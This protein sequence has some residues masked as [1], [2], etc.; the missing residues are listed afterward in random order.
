MLIRVEGSYIQTM[1]YLDGLLLVGNW[2]DENG[3]ASAAH[4]K[5]V[6]VESIERGT[7]KKLAI[8]VKYKR[9]KVVVDQ[10][11][12]DRLVKEDMDIRVHEAAGGVFVGDLPTKDHQFGH[13]DEVMVC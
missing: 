10:Q 8:L 1:Q 12:H 9:T 2:N 3:D 6:L 13:F 5:P 11:G 4:L 7:C